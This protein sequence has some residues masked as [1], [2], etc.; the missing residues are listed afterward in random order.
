MMPSILSS[1][2]VPPA[3]KHPHS[4]MYQLYLL[5]KLATLGLGGIQIF[6]SSFSSPG[7]YG[8]TDLVYHG[9]PKNA[10]KAIGCLLPEC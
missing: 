5:Y 8:I 7:I 4:M 6:V 1:A 9:I 3:A 2:P 10:K